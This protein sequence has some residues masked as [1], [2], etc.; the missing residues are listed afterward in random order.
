MTTQN[1]TRSKYKQLALS[2]LFDAIGMLSF[3]IPFIGEF[4][5]VIWAP[6]AALLM[7]KM[8]S[9]ITGKVAGVFAL[10]EELTIGLDFIPTFTLIWVYQYLIKGRKVTEK[11]I[12]LKS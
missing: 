9:G 2:L 12:D 5:D 11:I 10:F 3:T 1:N 4:S 6:I 8:Y 7:T